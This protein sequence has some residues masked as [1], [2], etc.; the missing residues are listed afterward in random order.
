MSVKLRR[1]M[2]RCEALGSSWAAQDVASATWCR[3][4]ETAACFHAAILISTPHAV[5]PSPEHHAVLYALHIPAQDMQHSGMSVKLGG[6]GLGCRTP[7]SYG[8][9][10]NRLM[11]WRRQLCAVYSLSS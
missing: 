8:G 4:D 2:V 7:S 6:R 10:H 5:L 3:G 11:L 9:C 1:Q